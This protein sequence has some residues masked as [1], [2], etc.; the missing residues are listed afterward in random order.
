MDAQRDLLSHGSARHQHRGLLTEQLSDPAFK[1]VDHFTLAVSVRP[2]LRRQRIS[3][4]SRRSAAP[5]LRRG[6]S[7]RSQPHMIA[8]QSRSVIRRAYYD[9]ATER[10]VVVPVVRHGRIGIWPFAPDV[11]GAP[12]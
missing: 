3:R 5:V 7:H 9:P 8:R 11:V 10:S 12:I 4:R 2:R 6:P 1:G